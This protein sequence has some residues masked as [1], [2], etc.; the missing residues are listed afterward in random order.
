MRLTFIVLAALIASPADAREPSW[1]YRAKT[2]VRPGER[3]EVELV[4]KRAF[5]RVEIALDRVE[6]GQKR[7][8]D[9][10]YRRWK[11][12]K[13]RVLKWK[14]PLGKSKWAMTLAGHTADGSESISV[15]F[16]IFASGPFDVQAV[17]SETDIEAGKITFTSTQPVTMV[18]LKGFDADGLQVLDT[19]EPLNAPAG[20]IVLAV[21]VPANDVLKR[22]ELKAYDGAGQWA[23]IRVVVWYTELPHDNVLFETA[24]WEVRPE[25]APKLDNVVGLISAELNAFR[26]MLGDEEARIESLSLYIAGM[27]DRVGTEADNR[28]LSEKRARAIAHY[29]RDK[30]VQAALFYAGFGEHHLAVPT[31]DEVAQPENRRAMYILANTKPTRLGAARWRAVK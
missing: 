23:T 1:Q 25:E 21:D 12:G 29:F 27:T 4:A 16:T 30:K 10:S 19:E 6:G 11:A 13:S 31:A 8:R 24:R 28:V 18:T 2:T 9:W 22:L 20:K 15:N 7:V 14:V 5:D 3:A 17:K 26:R